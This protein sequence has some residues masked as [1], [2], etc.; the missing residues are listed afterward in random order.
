MRRWSEIRISA[1]AVPASRAQARAELDAYIAVRVFGLNR[2][3]LS[4]QL[5]TFEVLRRRDETAHGQFR[6][7][8]L[9]LEA[10]ERLD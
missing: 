7:K 10:V 8:L 3:E 2:Q 1:L 6:T 9:I 5:D 4:D